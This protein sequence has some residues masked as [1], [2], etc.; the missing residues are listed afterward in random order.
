MKF[1]PFTLV[2]LS[3]ALASCRSTKSGSRG[4]ART[5]DHNMS[6]VEY[7]FD[8]DGNYR[9]DWVKNGGRTGDDRK[10]VDLT[11]DNP[12]PYTYTGA[13][14]P[15]QDR[16]RPP[17]T[18]SSSSRSGS[19]PKTTASTSRSSS[20]PK[21]KAKTKPTPKYTSIKVKKGDTLYGLAQRYGTSVKAIQS[22]NGM[23]SKTLLQDGRSL[24]I[25]R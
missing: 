2:V 3:L 8:E 11:V 4:D 5:P 12:R 10:V 15:E 1:F 17:K 19:K 18:A 14:I 13:T 16:P 25:P 9:E 24:K 20:K 7:P 23:G 6:E 22:A 21:P